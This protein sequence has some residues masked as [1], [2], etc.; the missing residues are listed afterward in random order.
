MLSFVVGAGRDRQLFEG[1]T[2]NIESLDA[3]PPETGIQTR[4][5][6]QMM[7]R[8]VAGASGVGPQDGIALERSCPLRPGPVA[9]EDTFGAFAARLS[10]IGRAHHE[11]LVNCFVGSLNEASAPRLPT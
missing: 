8:V 9:D 7:I 5:V 11:T 1:R 10:N 6:Q 4:R 3:H 2:E